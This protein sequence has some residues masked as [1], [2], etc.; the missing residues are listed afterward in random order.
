MI[1]VWTISALVGAGL[2]YV[3]LPLLAAAGLFILRLLGI[4]VL[5]CI[6][7]RV[8]MFLVFLGTYWVSRS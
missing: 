2:L 8:I 1:L 4:V 3:A 7:V 6:V 5:A